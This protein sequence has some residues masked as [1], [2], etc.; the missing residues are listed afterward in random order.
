MVCLSMYF[1]GLDGMFTLER[2][3]LCGNNTITNHHCEPGTLNFEV[4]SSKTIPLFL[5]NGT[6]N[7]NLPGGF[8]GFLYFFF[9]KI[10]MGE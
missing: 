2:G 8:G 7:A 3:E 1:S 6:W 10:R 4:Q 5:F 9:D